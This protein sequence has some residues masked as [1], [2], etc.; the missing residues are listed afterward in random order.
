MLIDLRQN[1]NRTEQI[2]YFRTYIKFIV[3]IQ[4]IYI[5]HVWYNSYTAII[6]MLVLEIIIAYVYFFKKTT[7][8]TH[9]HTHTHKYIIVTNTFDES[10]VTTSL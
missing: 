9:T 4:Y 3:T 8:H 2:F 1:K 7:K 6:R 5:C 10:K